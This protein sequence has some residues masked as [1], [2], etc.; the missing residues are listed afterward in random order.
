M[1]L[2]LALALEPLEAAA[3]DSAVAATAPELEALSLGGT[4]WLVTVVMVLPEEV[5]AARG[6][7]SSAGTVVRSVAGEHTKQ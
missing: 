3:M 6:R 4:A 5:L 1:A 7:G 2:E